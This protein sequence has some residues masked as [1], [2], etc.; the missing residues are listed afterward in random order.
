MNEPI[1]VNQNL[2]GNVSYAIGTLV[3]CLLSMLLVFMDFRSVKGILNVLAQNNIV[4]FLIKAILAFGFLFFGYCFLF[5]LKKAKRG[6]D[7][8]IVDEK[9][10]TDNSSDLAFGFIPWTDIDNIYMTS[11]VGNQFIEL[12]LN[13]EE[14]Y[15]Q[16]LSG[17]K[18]LAV[19]ANKKMGHQAVCITL[20][21]SGISPE[22]LFPEILEIFQ[23]AKPI[24]GKMI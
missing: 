6:K 13:N 17:M 2:K 18:K 19:L 7:I 4:Y 14:P 20:N 1:V 3:M 8:L 9:G 23:Q 5:V 22:G 11:V 21:S 15:L 24:C 12:V 10:I 16:K